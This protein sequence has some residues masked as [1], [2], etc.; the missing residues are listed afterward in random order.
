MRKINKL[1]KN[2]CKK[3]L[4]RRRGNEERPKTNPGLRRDVEL[5]VVWNS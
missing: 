3:D 5:V 1:S 4:F 2:Y